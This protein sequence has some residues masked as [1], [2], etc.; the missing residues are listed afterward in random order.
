MKKRWKKILFLTVIFIVGILL[1]VGM[2]ALE[3][4]MGHE[5]RGREL[6]AVF[7]FFMAGMWLSV[8]LHEGGHMICGLL[9]GYRFVSFRIG[10]VMLLRDES[11]FHLKQF[12]LAGTGGQCL[13]DPPDFQEGNFPYILY[14]LGGFLANLLAA[15]VCAIICLAAEPGEYGMLFCIVF[16]AVNLYL[17]LVNGIPLRVGGIDNDGKNMVS[18]GK[19]GAARRNLWLQLRVNGE[20]VRGKRLRDMPKEW[21]E[22][23]KVQELTDGLSAAMGSVAVSRL[24]DEQRFSEA[25]V[26]GEEVLEKASG[27]LD[28]QKKMLKGELL[29]MEIIGAQSADKLEEYNT[30]EFQKFLAVTRKY[31]STVRL[32]YAYALLWEKD[33][34]K[35]EKEKAYFENC[36]RVYPNKGEILGEKEL[37]TAVQTRA[38]Q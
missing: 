23:P 10:N 6:L 14:N 38:A 35:A 3:K 15:A 27:L 1:G 11:R 33:Q 24:L 2:A 13:L 37:M 9:S 8:V 19:S 31:P 34:V 20:L 32:K 36:I 29:F 28:I 7:V 4:H 5:L 21:F 17:G 12:S 25:A 18:M 30:K 26:L 16:G 22:L